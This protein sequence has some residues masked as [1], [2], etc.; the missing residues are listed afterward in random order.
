MR[1]CPGGPY[2]RGGKRGEGGGGR[3]HSHI[4]WGAPHPQLPE[5]PCY[6]F[7]APLTGRTAGWEPIIR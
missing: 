3:G 5:I 4:F 2:G 6:Q 1:G 7:F